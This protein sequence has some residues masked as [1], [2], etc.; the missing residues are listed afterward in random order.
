MQLL[1][2]AAGVHVEGLVLQGEQHQLGR[3]AQ[4]GAFRKLLQEI[5]ACAVPAGL[6]GLELQELA[7]LVDHEQEAAGADA[8]EGVL[9]AVDQREHMAR[10]HLRGATGVVDL[11][12]HLG[13]AAG[14][15]FPERGG[16][17]VHGGEQA[18]D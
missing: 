18:V 16:G 7:E 4:I 3:P 6:V 12:Q 17:S 13:F 2:H 1:A 11:L 9:Q 5:G 10:R 8:F 14:P 15:A